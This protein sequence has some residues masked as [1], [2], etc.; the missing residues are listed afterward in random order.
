VSRLKRVVVYGLIGFAQLAVF[1]N[2]SVAVLWAREGYWLTALLHA[3]IAVGVEF[4]TFVGWYSVTRRR[5][6]R[7]RPDDD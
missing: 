6:Y 7:W 1:A 3:A 4:S 5:P 2:L